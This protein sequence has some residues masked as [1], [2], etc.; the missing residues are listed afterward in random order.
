MV[1]CRKG[2]RRLGWLPAVFAFLPFF[3]LSPDAR[4]E[5]FLD[6]AQKKE[7]LMQG[8][9]TGRDGAQYDVWIVPG[10]DASGRFAREGWKSAGTELKRYENPQ[11][12]RDMG[13]MTRDILRY[14]R[15]DVIAEFALRG[16]EKAWQDSTSLARQRVQK[17][18]F[19]WWFAWPWAVLSASAES[20]VRTGIG[21]P[22]GVLLAGGDVVVTPATYLAWPAVMSAGYALGEGVGMPVVSGAW[23]TV[24]A[25]PLALAGQ[26]PAPERA[27]GFWMKRLKD[28]AED[29]IRAVL[30]TWQQ[31]WQQAADLARMQQELA[32]ARSSHDGAV[33]ALRAELEQENREWAGKGKALQA[34]Y[35]ELAVRR[36][37]AAMPAL[38]AAMATRGYSL[39]RLQ[40]ERQALQETLVA[41]GLDAD[42]ARQV[43]DALLGADT[44]SPARA[45]DEKAIPKPAGERP[46][47]P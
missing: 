16:T 42:G 23:N 30:A 34:G 11:H 8:R 19:G 27:D 4:G 46:P 22:G 1:H 12:Y 13:K 9:I 41:Q 15:K 37:V 38:R 43:L 36:A 24:V 26:Q 5:Y 44:S 6:G 31:Q 45:P 17:R 28:P 33:A 39:A 14:A 47:A 10:Y 2:V 29:D 20:V 25:P 32:A 35:R 3:C 18:V 7:L 40:A 21:V